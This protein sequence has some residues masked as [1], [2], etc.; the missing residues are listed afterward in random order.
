MSTQMSPLLLVAI[1]PGSLALA[2]LFLSLVVSVRGAMAG[3]PSRAGLRGIWSAFGCLMLAMAALA[4]S[5][6]AG[7]AVV[8]AGLVA[9]SSVIPFAAAARLR[10]RDDHSA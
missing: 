7:P 9:L 5:T 10:V 4:A 8:A 1:A 2:T 6:G 3:R